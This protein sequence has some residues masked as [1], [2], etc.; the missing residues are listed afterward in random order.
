MKFRRRGA[1]ILYVLML[2]PAML[3]LLYAMQNSLRVQALLTRQG[4]RKSQAF[5]LAESGLAWGYRQFAANGFSAMT[6]ESDGR[7]ISSTSTSYKAGDPATGVTYL[8]S[9]GWLQFKPTTNL[10]G[11][12]NADQSFQCQMYYPKADT[13][14]IRVRAVYGGDIA[15]HTLQ[16]GRGGST[17]HSIYSTGDLGELSRPGTTT[18]S[19]PV[20]ADKDL[21]LSPRGGT[22]QITSA[23]VQA[24]GQLYRFRD[25]WGQADVAG[26]VSIGGKTLNG[27][28]QG[29]SGKGN[30]MDSFNTS[31]ATGAATFGGA[32]KDG[33]LGGS[34]ANSLVF[35]SLAEYKA[36][37]TISIPSNMGNSS[38]TK[39]R[40]FFNA[41]EGRTVT[42]YEVDVDKMI[43]TGAYP[44]NGVLYAEGP[45]RLIGAGALP[46][47][48]T[49]ASNSAIY[50]TGDFNKSY[51]TAAALATGTPAHQPAMLVTS[52]RVYHLSSGYGNPT[53]AGSTP[54]AATDPAAYTGD[55]A[56]VVEVNAVVV[57]GAPTVDER[58]WVRE[59]AGV[60][61]TAF[62][63]MP[64]DAN[65]PPTGML[66]VGNVAS[67]GTWANSEDLLEDWTGLRLN[68]LG[69]TIHTNSATMAAFTN[70]NASDTIT[71]WIVRSFYKPPASRSY[72]FDALLNSKLPPMS[73]S[74]TSKAFW[75]VEQ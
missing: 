63:K 57:D 28:A 70:A 43:S 12:A 36:K 9:T 24:A 56:G 11:A 22:L 4:M 39:Q 59:H 75:A 35:P 49:V 20:Q 74:G 71:P 40:S 46:A 45:I 27:A 67:T 38:Y 55:P 68:R 30:A 34:K 13:W 32:V 25:A 73:P 17:T 47:P 58:E 48:L 5:Y 60:K 51:P 42:Y 7:A 26:T 50:T 53:G 41:A 6:H 54:P 2:L 66:T 19:G 61:N 16:G 62:S 31:W 37:A 8:A 72:T 18:V 21:F 1:T 3:I 64:A 65:T 69:S 15:V 14:M 10:F 29:Q 33:A 44:T 23:S 52:D